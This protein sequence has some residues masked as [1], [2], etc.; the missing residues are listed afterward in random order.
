MNF[1]DVRSP[2]SANNFRVIRVSSQAKILALCNVLA[3]L[4]KCRSHHGASGD[5]NRG[6][7]LVNRCRNGLTLHAP[8]S[9]NRLPGVFRVLRQVDRA[10]QLAGTASYRADLRSSWQRSNAFGSQHHV[11]DVAFEGVNSTGKQD[12]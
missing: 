10:D 11:G 2:V 7:V 3:A 9:S 8:N 4:G 6:L 5:T 12:F 1:A